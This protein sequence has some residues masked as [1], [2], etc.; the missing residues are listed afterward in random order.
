MTPFL[1]RAERGEGGRAI[2]PLTDI[3]ILDL[4]TVL[5]GPYATQ[6][7][8]DLGADVIKVEGP[9]GDSTRAI[10]PARHPGMSGTVLNLHRN[11]RSVVLDLKRPAGRE[12]LLRL[13][14]RA[15]AAGARV[16][17]RRSRSRCSRRSSR[18]TWSS[19]TRGGRSSHPS[20]RPDTRGYSPP[21]AG[22]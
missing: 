4:T 18:S 16:T 12:A 7:L 1:S 19:T 17:G 20:G 11:K 22:R 10:G 2:G 6:I 21:S 14:Q 15:A 3:R 9:E 13:A 8:G 5:M